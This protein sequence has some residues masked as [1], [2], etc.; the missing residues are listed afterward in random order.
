V[1]RR[2]KSSIAPGLFA[3]LGFVFLG[4]VLAWWFSAGNA[5]PHRTLPELVVADYLED[6]NTLRGNTYKVTGTVEESL[7]WSPEGG[8]LIAV[9]TDGGIVPVL[10]TAEFNGMNIQKEQKLV[11]V[12]EVDEKG[13]LRTRGVDK[14]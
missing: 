2:K 6:S 3:A 5:G 14:A 9:A 10:V 11:L 4:L 1:A 8:R 7:A 12:V 13:I